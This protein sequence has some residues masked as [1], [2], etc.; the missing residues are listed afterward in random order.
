MCGQKCRCEKAP[1][2][3]SGGGPFSWP[4]GHRNHRQPSFRMRATEWYWRILGAAGDVGHHRAAADK[5]PAIRRPPSAP[6]APV[7]DAPC[8]PRAQE[9]ACWGR[10]DRRARAPRGQL[11]TAEHE[12]RKQASSAACATK[13]AADRT[14]PVPESLQIARCERPCCASCGSATCAKMKNL[15]YAALH[16]GLGGTRQDAMWPSV[17]PSRKKVPAHALPNLRNQPRLDQP[18]L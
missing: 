8:R 13:L 3:A 18:L 16:H 11:A 4:S 14:Q 6:V 1:R 12:P 10:R 5:D 2:C 15:H 9:P 7:A 17:A